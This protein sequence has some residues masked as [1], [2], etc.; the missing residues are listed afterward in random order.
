MAFHDGQNRFHR[1]KSC[2]DVQIHLSVP[3]FFAHLNGA[4]RLRLADVVD[5]N[6]D[7]TQHVHAALYHVLHIFSDR[8]IGGRHMGFA[9]FFFDDFL[10][11]FGGI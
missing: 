8:H 6:V 9:T 3:C 10:G 1:Q 7:A 4:T 2:F 5:Q 11:H